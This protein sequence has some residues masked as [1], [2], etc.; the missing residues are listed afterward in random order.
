M[1]RDTGEHTRLAQLYGRGTND[2]IYL[3]VLA[4]RIPAHIFNALKKEPVH[5]QLAVGFT[6]ALARNACKMEGESRRT[7][8]SFSNYRILRGG[9]DGHI[10]PEFCCA[11]VSSSAACLT[12]GNYYLR[13]LNNLESGFVCFSGRGFIYIWPL[14]G[15]TGSPST[16]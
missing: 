10:L 7:E 5:S 9:G 12:N 4:Q 8:L 16:P 11:W 3:T 15:P 14:R 6:L 1:R 13:L 2:C